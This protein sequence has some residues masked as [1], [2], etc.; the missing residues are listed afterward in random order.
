M[1]AQNRFYR[2]DYPEYLKEELGN[3]FGPGSH[4]NKQSVPVLVARIY[5]YDDTAKTWSRVSAEFGDFTN[6]IQVT[7]GPNTIT[8]PDASKNDNANVLTKRYDKV[9]TTLVDVVS[10]KF[11]PVLGKNVAEENKSTAQITNVKLDVGGRVGTTTRGE[12]TISAKGNPEDLN[13][14]VDCVTILGARIELAIAHQLGGKQNDVANALTYSGRIYDYSFTYETDLDFTVN[15]KTIG[16]ADTLTQLSGFPT[17]NI[18]KTAT[19]QPK[20]AVKEYPV[21]KT[22]D[23]NG[24][25]IDLPVT[26]LLQLI[27]A[28]IVQETDPPPTGK[29]KG[30]NGDVLDIKGLPDPGGVFD[31]PYG[32]GQYRTFDGGKYYLNL[33]AIRLLYMQVN[34][35]LA[36]L[37]GNKT[38]AKLKIRWMPGNTLLEK[39]PGSRYD[40]LFSADPTKIL[41]P[42]TLADQQPRGF[43]NGPGGK[44]FN[45]A[46][47]AVSAGGASDAGNIGGI[48][49]ERQVIFDAA[50]AKLGD[51][52]FA[53]AGTKSVEAFF[54]AIFKEIKTQSGGVLDL[55]LIS[56]TEKAL[57]IPDISSTVAD[58]DQT[59]LYIVDRNYVK[60]ED[61]KPPIL[62]FPFLPGV[63][64]PAHPKQHHF[65]DFTSKSRGL[66]AN[67]PK[68]LAAKAFI[69]DVNFVA[70]ESQVTDDA[71]AVDPTE[72]TPAEIQLKLDE[73]GKLQRRLIQAVDDTALVNSITPKVQQILADLNKM[74]AP[75][76]APKANTERKDLLLEKAKTKNFTTALTLSMSSFGISGFKWGHALALDFIPNTAPD[77]T[78]FS[79][80]QITHTIVFATTTDRAAGW[81]TTINCLARL[82]PP[83]ELKHQI[84]VT[85]LTGGGTAH[86][87]DTIIALPTAGNEKAGTIKYRKNKVTGKTEVVPGTGAGNMPSISDRGKKIK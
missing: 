74:N 23:K 16:L 19:V 40:W 39:A 8:I 53:V 10:G 37:T 4:R 58:I 42:N 6:V 44:V 76:A 65:K 51:T 33:E 27:D 32:M 29:F 38:L 82:R 17:Y 78:V 55:A 61:P 56:D 24:N 64:N 59:E 87:T 49:I 3:R 80:N 83:A 41:I 52:R 36:D 9:T 28:I 45:F 20:G 62:V 2:T 30:R 12:I 75:N 15:I 35:Y 86:A 63:T 18:D 7:S 54:D 34:E 70:A 85:D 50:G 21:I 48:Y 66:S 31:K 67:V 69:R 25:A 79:I 77:N 81:E 57:N 71:A 14:L 43:T 26:N 46:T 47:T 68:S 72:I 73:L 13:Q 84:N 22:K 1:A 5:D 11:D 60:L